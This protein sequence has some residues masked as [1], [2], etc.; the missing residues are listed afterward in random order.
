MDAHF[1]L[2]GVEASILSRYAAAL[3]TAYTQ[4]TSARLV[5][6]PVYGLCVCAPTLGYAVALVYGG[7]LIAREDMHYEYAI[8]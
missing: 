7:Y 4:S 5:R 3:H 8:L 2:T 6:G 1:P